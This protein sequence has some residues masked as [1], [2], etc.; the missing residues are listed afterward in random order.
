M[1]EETATLEVSA[2]IKS[3][4]DQIANLTLKQARELADYLEAEYEIKAAAGGGMIAMP[5]GGAGAGG[6]GGAAP[7]PTEFDVVLTG[8]GDKKIGVIKEVR[9]LTG[10]GLKEAKECVESVPSKVKEGVSKEE[11]EEVKKKLE[12]AGASVEI[13]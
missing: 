6:D 10:L 1:S 11:A 8:F 7:E 4:G 2:E 5:V 13:K 9:A 3:L 12:D